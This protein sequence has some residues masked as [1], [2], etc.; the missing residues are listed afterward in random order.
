M[1]APSF[2][3]G[4]SPDRREIS[5]GG[6]S[7]TWRVNHFATGGNAF[8][9]DHAIADK[10]FT[11]PRLVGFALADPVNPYSMSYRATEYGFLFVLLTFAAFVMVEVIWGVRLH[12]VQYALA[13]AALAVFFL[14][15]IALSEHIRFGSAYIAAAGACVA[16]LTWYLRHPLRSLARTAAFGALFSALYGALYVLLRSEDHSLLLGALL[17]FGMLAAVMILTRKLDWA[18]L[19]RRLAPAAPSA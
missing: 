10:L 5:A 12:P 14:L 6:F 7:A 19:S 1:A 4:Y 11:A 17:V 2:I 18:A 3:G 8:W 13:G 16:L 15:L 9:V